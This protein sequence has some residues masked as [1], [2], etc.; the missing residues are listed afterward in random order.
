MNLLDV[1][2]GTPVWTS[3]G[4]SSRRKMAPLRAR[5]RLLSIERLQDRRPS[6]IEPMLAAARWNG[7]VSALSSPPWIVD[8][9]PGPNVTDKETIL[10]LARMASNAYETDPSSTSWEDVSYGGFNFSNSFGWEGDG[11]RGHIFADSRNSTIVMGLKGTTAAVFDGAGTTTNDKVNDNLF[12][13]CCCAQGG[14]YF[15]RQVCDCQT[16]TYTCNKTC[17]VKA[18]RDE[19][20]YYRASLDLYANVTA[21]Y[22]DSD[23]WIVG[24]SLG[25][26]VGSLLG[27]TYGLPVVTYEAPPQA[28]AATRLGLPTPPG[29]DSGASQYRKLTG[30]YHVGHTADPIFMGVC[31]GA[32]SLC[33]LGGYA[34]ET[35]CHTGSRCV[36]DVVADKGWRSGLGTHKISSVINDVIKAY[37]TVP[38]C[39]LDEECIDCYNWK[40]F[41]SNE[42]TSTTTKSSS[43]STLTRTRTSTCK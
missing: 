38:K 23:V 29:S 11:L 28:L 43:T 20:R 14:R 35:A 9:I 39:E 34:M 10:N 13:S 41:E 7:G 19:N 27:L 21:L 2:S 3:S 37:D 25:G 31:N 18:L 16:T 30:V 15:W 5:S 24:H 12:F 36:Y 6:V 4:A 33:S 32:T 1:T 26:S 8:D 22:P 17:V 40:Y 42:S